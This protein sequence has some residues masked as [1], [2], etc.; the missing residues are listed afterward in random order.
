MALLQTA[1]LVLEKQGG[2]HYDRFRSR[3]VFPILNEAGKVVAFG[4]RSLDGSEPKYLNSPETPVYQKSRT[5]YGLS[6][7]KDASRKEGRIVLMEG[8]LDVAR[9]LEGGVGEAVATCGTAM[10]AAHARLLHRF[11]E[12]VVVNFDQDEAGQKAARRSLDILVA[13]GL[14]VH[15]VELPEG[16]DPDSFVKEQGGEAYRSRLSSAAPYMEWLIRRA[17]SRHDTKTP[18]GKG[19]YLA[20]LLPSLVGIENAVERA[21]WLPIVVQRGSLD[22]AAALSELKRALGSRSSEV[23]SPPPRAAAP[24]RRAR[25]LPAEK[26]L[27]AFLLS[28][29]PRAAT[30]LD[31]LAEADIAGLR[32]APALEAAQALA[33]RGQAINLTSLLA[34]VEE[35]EVRR[36]LSEIAVGGAPEDP[37][38]AEGCVEELKLHALERRQAEMGKGL[39]GDDEDSVLRQINDLARRTHPKELIEP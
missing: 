12:M 16:H 10:T 24:P 6:W 39:G 34:E 4:A 3:A 27:L 19:A 25:L 35:D 13:E 28:G 17:A 31:D 22:E 30:T 15:V 21:A 36:M 20:E 9:A 38:T 2:G 7:A 18:A 37:L 23:A 1:G 33:S 14:L 26:W 29:A 11:T 5:L 32:S 8:Y